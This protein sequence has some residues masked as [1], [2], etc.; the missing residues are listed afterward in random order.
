M[1]AI[2]AGFT[3][4]WEIWAICLVVLILFGGAAI[5]KFAKSLGRAKKEFEEGIKSGKKEGDSTTDDLA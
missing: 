3:G 2:I 1:N 5:P 4:G